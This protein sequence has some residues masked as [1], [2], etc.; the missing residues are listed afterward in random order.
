[1]KLIG[2]KPLLECKSGDCHSKGLLDSG[3]QIS[4]LCSKWVLE[5]FPDAELLP[6]A[7]LV[8]HR[9]NLT[10]TAANNTEVLMVGRI[11]LDFA[12]GSHSFPVPFFGH[13]VQFITPHHWT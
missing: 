7:D 4:L 3:S 6:I 9:E 11:I 1:M 5:K 2:D 13:E 12:I 10:F 8:E